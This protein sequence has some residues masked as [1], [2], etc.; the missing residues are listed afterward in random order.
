MSDRGA[1]LDYADQLIDG[2]LE[3]G[4]RSTRV[5]AVLARSAFEDWLDEQC[6]WAATAA[7]RPSTSAKLAVLDA[8]DDS[9]VGERAKRVWHGLSRVC[10]H[11]SYELHPSPY[12][13]RQL[14]TEVRLLDACRVTTG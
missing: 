3:L 4:A 2:S 10:H 12:E 9:A 7:T 1:L 5:A 11:H 14:V 6:P 13:V 8:L